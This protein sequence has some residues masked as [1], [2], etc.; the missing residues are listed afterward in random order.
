[1][2]FQAFKTR[3]GPPSLLWRVALTNAAVLAVAVGALAL[4]PATVSFPIAPHEAVVLVGGLVAGISLNLWLLRRAFRPL[5]QLSG[6]MRRIDPLRPGLRVPV[7]GDDAEVVHITHA[8]NDMLDRLEDER[9][10]SMRRGLRA[11]EEERR[12]IALE[13][14]DEVGQRL[15]AVMLHVE[16]LTRSADEPSDDLAEV[17][18]A[19][20]ETLEEVRLLAQRLRP[21]ALDD[22]GLPRALAS[23]SQRL[24][25]HTGLEITSDVE[26]DLPPLSEDA[27]LAIYRIAQEGLT[28]AVRH[29]SASRLY[30]TLKHGH[31]G[32]VLSVTDNGRGTDGRASAGWGIRAMRERAL[33]IGA[34]LRLGSVPGGGTD[35]RL[36]VPV[37]QIEK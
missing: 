3:R 31:D 36:D 16:R 9:R 1:M 14:H 13:L 34:T 35:L 20:R 17:R 2:N 32:I 25:H 19:V 12:R 8:F 15:T 10:E 23:L 22:L 6:V 5:S 4:S 27:E 33:S 26:R 37:N 28:N 18:E 30:L 11:Q 7:Y 29:S 24:S 21:E